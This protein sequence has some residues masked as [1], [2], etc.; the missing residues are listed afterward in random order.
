MRG[1]FPF[2]SHDVLFGA[3]VQ[4]PNAHFFPV[5]HREQGDAGAD[6]FGADPAFW[7]QADI[8]PGA[9]LLVLVLHSHT[10]GN[11]MG[12]PAGKMQSMAHGDASIPK[13]NPP[14]RGGFF[15]FAKERSKVH[16]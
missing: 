13:K 15:C 9:L 5:S 14:T 7:I 8:D 2:W 1:A 6:E 16:R 12:S 10:S 3:I 4:Y 11:S